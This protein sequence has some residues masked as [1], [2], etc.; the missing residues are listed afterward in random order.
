MSEEVL[1]QGE[2]TISIL[3]VAQKEMSNNLE[4][5]QNSFF[6][7]YFSLEHL[8]EKNDEGV[9]FQLILMVSVIRTLLKMISLI[10]SYYELY[11]IQLVYASF[12]VLWHKFTLSLSNELYA[13]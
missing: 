10:T 12:G 3:N 9:H 1:T 7:G 13:S 4:T 2:N 6:E 5:M 11:L 8:E